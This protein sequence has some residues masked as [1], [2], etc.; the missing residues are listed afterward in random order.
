MT[1]WRTIAPG[2]RAR[3]HPIRR[4]GAR[5]DLYFTLR[6]T[7]GG[8][9]HEEKLGW[10]SEGWTV[11]RAQEQLG[12]LNQAQRTGEGPATLREQEALV[13]Q[14]FLAERTATVADLWV[15]YAAEIVALNKPSTAAQKARMW[16]RRINPMIG[17]LAIDAVTP[18]DA[19]GVVR[20]PLR[21]DPAGLV[22]GGRGEAGN[23]YRLLH[24]MFSKALAW[25]VRSREIGN[26]LEEIAEPKSPR[27]ERLLTA[28][29]ISALQQ[30][31]DRAEAEGTEAQ[32]LVAVIRLLILTGAR[33]GELLHLRHSE[34]RRDEMELHLTDTKVGF[35]R[36]P[37]S[38]AA[39]A[40][41]DSVERMPGV[42]YVFRAINAP[43][44]PL[45]YDTI[46]KAFGR[47]AQAA[48][49]RC[50][51]HALRHWFSTMTANSVSNPRIGMALTGHKSHS[52]YL[53]Y[54][55]GDKEQ[56]RA[57]AEQLATLVTGLGAASPNVVTL[58]SKKR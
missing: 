35:S 2:I 54:I 30:A 50:S 5:R 53:N 33:V 25:R 3:E 52:A 32:H 1:T 49:V 17:A 19:G 27:R 13:T 39:L 11:K 40:V 36:R 26:P 47:V 7:L 22:V 14:R 15:R 44:R 48:G 57:L 24:H 29:E 31:L 12:K 34:I 6:Y 4:H 9:R 41:L 45:P 28:G 16:R 10:A 56:A 21:L 37:L 38:A 8:K 23:L 51:L 58:P 18:E 43:T 42:E 46:E 55:H 20:S